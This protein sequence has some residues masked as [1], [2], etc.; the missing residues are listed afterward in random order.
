MLV[1][2]YTRCLTF[3]ARPPYGPSDSAPPTV[4]LLYNCLLPLAPIYSWLIDFKQTCTL[5][6]GLLFEV[7]HFRRELLPDSAVPPAGTRLPCVRGAYQIVP[8]M[9]DGRQ[10]FLNLTCND[11]HV[12]QKQKVRWSIMMYAVFGL[13]A[14]M[15]QFES[16]TLVYSANICCRRNGRKCECRQIVKAGAIQYAG[17][18]LWRKKMENR[19]LVAE[20]DWT[21]PV[22]YCLLSESSF[23]FFSYP[24]QLKVCVVASSQRRVLRFTP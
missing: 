10:E 23:V 9:L 3:R 14:S 15:F 21:L 6:P 5:F 19:Y 11:C 13:E 16:G 17:R 12:Y 1:A 24:G 22:V 20:E 18:L 8:A 7:S 4:C 2:K